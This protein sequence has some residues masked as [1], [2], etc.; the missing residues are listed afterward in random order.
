MSHNIAKESADSCLREFRTSLKTNREK[1]KI[2][3]TII[4]KIRDSYSTRSE[5][6]VNL[7]SSSPSFLRGHERSELALR[8]REEEESQK[9]AQESRDTR[10]ARKKFY[11]LAVVRNT[12]GS[13]GNECGSFTRVNGSLPFLGIRARCTLLRCILSFSLLSSRLRP[14]ARRVKA[15]IL[16]CLPIINRLIT[17]AFRTDEILS[18]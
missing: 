13:R 1:L 17:Y 2:L 11:E 14:S 15:C 6:C 4:E 18:I 10:R 8:P 12:V 9:H 7:P 5:P 3:E 16:A